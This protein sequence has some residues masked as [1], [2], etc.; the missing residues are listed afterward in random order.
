MLAKKIK[1]LF[2]QLLLSALMIFLLLLVGCSNYE[3]KADQA[4]SKLSNYEYE[5]GLQELTEFTDLVSE[6]SS[7]ESKSKD[8]EKSI[9]RYLQSDATLASK[10][11][12]SQQLSIIG[13]E[14]SLSVLSKLLEDKETVD[15]AL[16]P[17]ERIPGT[18]VDRILIDHLNSKDKV[19]QIGCINSLGVRKC[20]TSVAQIAELMQSE[21]LDIAIAAASALGNIH[22]D[23]SIKILKS[24]LSKTDGSLKHAVLDSYLKCVDI[25]S[26]KESSK[27]LAMYNDLY[28]SDLGMSSRQAALVGLISISDKKEAIILNSIQNDDAELKYVCIQQIRQ[29]P[30]RESISKFSSMLP[31]LSP[32]NQIH[33]LGVIKDRADKESK[34]HVLKTLKSKESLVRIASLQ[35]L[36]V[37]GDNSDVITVATIAADQSGVERRNARECLNLIND[38]KANNVIVKNISLADKKVKIELIRSAGERDI[39]SSFDIILKNTESEDRQVRSA[40]YLA[41]AEIATDNDLPI[42]FE[43]LHNLSNKSNRQKMERTILRILSVF[44]D[45]NFVKILINNI[46]TDESLDNKASSIKLLGV[47]NSPIALK[48]LRENI[49]SENQTIKIGAVEGLSYWGTPEPLYDLM[50]VTEKAQNEKVR[51]IALKGFTKFIAMDKSLSDSAKIELY[52]KSLKYAKTSNEKNLALDGIGHTDNLASLDVLELYYEDPSVKET[53]EDGINRVGWHVRRKHPEEVK[54]FILEI[55]KMTTSESYIRKSKDLIIEIDRILK[56][57]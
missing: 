24:K 30:E 45:E 25:L 5:E 16:Y 33:M 22:N 13:T 14:N 11:F 44:P 29:L 28:N 4:L 23:E 35:A 41:I 40:S 42:L 6:V 43:K 36:T 2:N 51:E 9:I 38:A 55:I 53:V 31:K 49:N 52:K 56:E 15:I 54:A 17:L 18:S 21:D 19:I 50:E 12:V 46:D 32:A 20:E 34:T 8:V 10:R 57:K 27:A 3:E 26:K 37:I 47:T 1:I 39:K 48:K 7:S